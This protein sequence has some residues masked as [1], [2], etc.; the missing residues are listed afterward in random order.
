M[1]FEFEFIWVYLSLF[2]FLQV[3]EDMH[4][5]SWQRA[6]RLRGDPAVAQCCQR[7]VLLVID[8]W[9][10]LDHLGG[11]PVTSDFSRENAWCFTLVLTLQ[12]GMLEKVFL[13][14]CALSFLLLLFSLCI[15][16]GSF[17]TSP[18]RWSVRFHARCQRRWPSSKDEMG[19]M[20]LLEMGINT[21]MYIY[22]YRD[23]FI[24]I[25]IP[26]HCENLRTCRVGYP[27]CKWNR[28]WYGIWWTWKL[29]RKVW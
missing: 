2:E 16:S 9:M 18:V 12:R 6:F 21:Y 23:V 8:D 24:Y 17:K 10:T 1:I 14:I 7:W 15:I 11:T 3:Q 4:P 29:M 22:T 25:Y 27:G 19:L 28:T 5:V 26:R 20:S 13:C